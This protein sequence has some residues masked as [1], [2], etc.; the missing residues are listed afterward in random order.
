MWNCVLVNGEYR[1]FDATW[2]SGA[3]EEKQRRDF[4]LVES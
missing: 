2:D 4:E 1:Y 3:T